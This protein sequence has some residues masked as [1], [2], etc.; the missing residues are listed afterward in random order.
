MD[1]SAVKL[2]WDSLCTKTGTTTADSMKTLECVVRT[3]LTV[4]GFSVAR[5]VREKLAAT[6]RQMKS[7]RHALRDTVIFQLPLPMM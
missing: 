5:G 3:F 1:T 6:L 4:K 2:C 7:L